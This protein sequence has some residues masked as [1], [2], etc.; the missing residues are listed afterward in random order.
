MLLIS[1]F[2]VFFLLLVGD[3]VGRPLVLALRVHFEFRDSTA[4]TPPNSECRIVFLYHLFSLIHEL[5]CCRVVLLAGD[6]AG[7]PRHWRAGEH[8]D[9]SC[10]DRKFALNLGIRFH[11]PDEFFLD[12]G[13]FSRSLGVVNSKYISDGVL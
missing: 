11:T 2:F 1:I 13:V 8:G 12:D 5:T 9:H 6:A 3:A 4:L 10:S 7:R